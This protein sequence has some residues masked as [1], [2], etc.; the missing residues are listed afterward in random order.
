MNMS[1]SV[2]DKWVWLM[3]VIDEYECDWWVWLMNMSVID[4]CDW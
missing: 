4:E 2:I 3:S 1:V